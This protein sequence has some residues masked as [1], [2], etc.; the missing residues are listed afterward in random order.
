MVCVGQ[1]F[2]QLGRL[3]SRPNTGLES[4]ALKFLHSLACGS[5]ITIK[6]ISSRPNGPPVSSSGG[7]GF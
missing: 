5:E 7:D 4:P 2:Y 3:S 6:T 1:R